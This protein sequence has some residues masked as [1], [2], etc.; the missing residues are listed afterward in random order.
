MCRFPI[1]P[2]GQSEVSNLQNRTQ[3]YSRN[4]GNGKSTAYSTLGGAIVSCII[5]STGLVTS[6]YAPAGTWRNTLKTP[7][8]WLMNFTKSVRIGHGS[9][10]IESGA[11]VRWTW[12]QFGSYIVLCF[13]ISVSSR[14]NG[15][16]P[17]YMASALVLPLAN[18]GGVSPFP[19][20]AERSP[21]SV[22]IGC[23]TYGFVLL[24]P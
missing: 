3:G 19:G 24:R 10:G 11:E 9:R 6:T 12:R 7:E 21:L 16:S 5:L 15:F 4:H 17:V 14:L 20:S 8:T 22:L 1:V 13:I 2:H 18:V 23:G